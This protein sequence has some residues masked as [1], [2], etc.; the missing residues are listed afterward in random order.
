MGSHSQSPQDS[1]PRNSGGSV[2]SGRSNRSGA[3]VVQLL[4]SFCE[5]TDPSTRVLCFVKLVRWIRSG[6]GSSAASER[7]DRLNDVLSLL[8][9]DAALKTRFQQTFHAM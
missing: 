7:V 9:E 1:S 4:D 5:Q 6:K 8:E 3:K 2:D